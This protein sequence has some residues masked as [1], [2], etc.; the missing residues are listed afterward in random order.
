MRRA[1]RFSFVTATAIV[2]L[3]C[4]FSAGRAQADEGAGF[5]VELAPSADSY[6]PLRVVVRAFGATDEPASSFVRGCQGHVVPEDAPAL[7]E[8]TERLERLAF[9]AAGEGLVGL[10]LGTPDGLYRCALAGEDGLAVSELAG[11]APGRYSVWLAGEEGAR[12]DARIF[13]SDMPISALELTGLDVASLGDPRAGRHDFAP[14]ED[15]ARQRLVEG[16]TLYA[17]QPMQPLNPAYCPGYGRFDAA[18]AVL[19]LDAAESRFSIMAQSDR[20]L[21]LA[22]RAP[23]GTILCNDDASGFNPAV[24]FETAEAG[25]YHI[26]VGGYGQG[27]SGQYDL[28][29]SRGGPAFSDATFDASAPPRLGSVTFDAQA[30]AQSLGSGPIVATDP[31]EMLPIG[32]YCPGFTG[33]DAPDMVVQLDEA[34]PQ[35][36]I[37][38]QS[39]TDL[40]LAVRGP[41]GQWQCNDDSFQFNPAVT[42]S[43]AQAGDYQVFVGAY[44][45][46]ASGEFNLYAAPG[47]PDWQ[48]AGGDSGTGLDP[49]AVPAVGRVEFGPQTRVDPRVIF[50]VRPSTT[51]AF[52]LGEGCAG[53]I[54]PERPDLV[55]AAEAG[56]PQLMV[57]MVSEADGTIVVVDPDG[58]IHCND[59]FEGLNP[60][61]MIPNPSPGDY[62]VFAGTYGGNGG[63]ATLGATIANPLWVMDREH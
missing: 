11:A 51:E 23:D 28:F 25:D 5:A 56:L 29:A 1:H 21:T 43:Q 34:Q 61:V 41:D 44:S 3:G 17:D 49:D 33:I 27:G 30:G 47:A 13:A 31:L 22:V 7:F 39:Q 53:F 58:G 26:F 45:Q 37:Y 16:G 12:L 54:T 19:T 40:V 6:T 2:A 60:G 52:G 14:G 8:V 50:D 48:S 32:S 36:S 63:V 59:D 18:D 20:D 38:A 46:G 4:A 24:T 42:F 10:V 55:I 35:L 9:T 62:A 15:G 57:Y